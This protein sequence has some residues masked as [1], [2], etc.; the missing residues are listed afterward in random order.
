VEE[1]NVTNGSLINNRYQTLRLLGEGGFGQT[2]LTEDTHLPSRRQC[3][4]KILKPVEENNPQLQQLIR[5]RFY[6]EAAV[7]EDLGENNSQIPKLYAYFNEGD[8]YYLIQEFVAGQ[9]LLANVVERGTFDESRTFNLL[10]N[11]LPILAFIHSKGIVHRDIKPENIILRDSDKMPVLIDFGAVRETVGTVLSSGGNT[12]SIVIGTPGFMSMEQSI[13]RPLFASDIYSLGMTVVFA[14]TGR[15]PNQLPTDP[16]TGKTLWRDSATQISP[17]LQD[18]IDRCIQPDA[19]DRYINANL[20]I[21][22]LNQ[23]ADNATMAAY[24]PQPAAIRQPPNPYP[25][26]PPVP[27][28]LAVGGNRDFVPPPAVGSNNPPVVRSGTNW[29]VIAAIVATTLLL[30]TIGFVGLIIFAASQLPDTPTPNTANSGNSPSNPSQSTEPSSSPPAT[31]AASPSAAIN[32]SRNEVDRA[33]E[34]GDK[35]YND[36]DI[37]GALAEYN[38]A[39]KLAPNDPRGY[40]GRGAIYEVKLRQSEP[41]LA[42][43][44]RAIQLAP[45]DSTG[46]RNRADLKN[47]LLNDP[48]GAKA[49]YD[50]AISLNPNDTVALVNRGRLRESKLNDPT[51]ALTDYNQAI[52]IDSNYALAYVFRGELKANKINSPV[53]ALADYDRA[54]KLAP[55]EPNYLYDRGLLKK[56][57]LND[58]AGAIADFQAAAKIYRQQ[59]RETDLQ[60]AIER[61]KEL[62]ATEK[63]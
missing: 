11:L 48:Q 32:A 50:R 43:Y 31:A 12:R 45:K 33:I 16:A 38:R 58:K 6:R 54:I 46:Y 22:A 21:E 39:I 53:A 15:S 3:V 4:V 60:D 20:A 61:L 5:E 62:N 19:K 55:E 30:G 25:S 27:E 23:I 24:Q 17:P 28:T 1:V 8:R 42:D 51:G 35:K 56:N 26:P 37:N 49:D 9:T 13:G 36:N 59:N 40:N 29:P 18:I 7:L 14:V 10:N 41:A 34:A 52:S 47:S 44:N 2:F 57:H 63:P